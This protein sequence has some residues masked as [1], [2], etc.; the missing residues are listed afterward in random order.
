ML[1]GNKGPFKF[2]IPKAGVKPEEIAQA[3]RFGFAIT[4]AL[5]NNAPLDRPMLTGLGAVS[6]RHRLIASE[7]VG[8]RS[9]K[10]WGALLRL[11]GK[12]GAFARRCVIVLYILFLFCLIITVIPVTTVIKRMLEPLL[13]KRIERQRAYYSA[14]SGEGR[15]RVLEIRERMQAKVSLK[16]KSGLEAE[17]P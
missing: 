7:K 14:P 3:D 10:A 11:L 15:E 17:A 8:Q 6:I 2:G 5:N 9:F 13:R 1:S 12:R 4:E 16:N